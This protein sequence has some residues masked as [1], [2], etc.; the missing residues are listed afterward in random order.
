MSFCAGHYEFSLS[1][2]VHRQFV[3]RLR[4]VAHSEDPSANNWIN[5]VH[6]KYTETVKV[7][8]SLSAYGER[9]QAVHGRCPA[10]RLCHKARGAATER[11]ASGQHKLLLLANACFTSQTRS[12]ANTCV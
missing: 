11:T 3:T 9:L 10:F 2:R 12:Q 1:S 5:I 6:D 4:D 7:R 8:R